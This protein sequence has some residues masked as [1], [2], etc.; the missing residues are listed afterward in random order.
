MDILRGPQRPQT[1]LPRL[2]LRHVPRHDLRRGVPAQRPRW[3]STAPW[4]PRERHRPARRPVHGFRRRSTP[5]RPTARR[6][7][8]AAGPRPRAATALYQ[9]LVRPLITKPL[10]VGSRTLSTTAPTE[11]TH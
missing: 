7:R 4:T 9:G 2:L 5:T 1:H 3:C 11:S 8:P 10:A 6:A